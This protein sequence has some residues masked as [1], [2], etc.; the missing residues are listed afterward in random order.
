MNDSGLSYRLDQ[1]EFDR[2]VRVLLQGVDD[3]LPI[4]ADL[5]LLLEESVRWNFRVGGR[6]QKW[7]A[8]RRA[9]SQAGYGE[10]SGQ[11]LVDTGRLLNSITSMGSSDTI[12]VGT[13]V[14]YAAAHHFGVDTQINERVRAHVRR[15]S[16][17]FGKQLPLTEVQVAAHQRSR[18]LKLPARPFML[19]QDEDWDDIGELV[20][21][22]I[23]RLLQR[24]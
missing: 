20:S 9:D 24:S 1:A 5:A 22:N 13:N 18:H 11:T 2:S 4:A 8:S 21:A 14:D 7:P 12:R 16:Q 23:Q 17:A 19:I 3:L 6:P 10:D 15:I